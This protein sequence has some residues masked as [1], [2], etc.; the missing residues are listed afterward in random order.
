MLK[1]RHPILKYLLGFMGCMAV[2]YLIYFSSFYQNHFE[3]PLVYGQAVI[4]NLL[5]HLLGH[6]TKVVGSAIAS[7]YFSVDIQNGCDGLEPIAILVSGILIY[8]ASRKQKVTGLAWGIG[9]LAI[10][11]LFRIVG[12]YLAGLNFSKTVFEILHVQ[13]GFI[14]FAMISVS[15]LFIWMNWVMAQSS[16]PAQ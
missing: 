12:L 11:N 10:L 7:T 2:F 1:D 6:D 13:G 5:L 4:G 14:V 8:P 16:K 9:V 3:K 15:L